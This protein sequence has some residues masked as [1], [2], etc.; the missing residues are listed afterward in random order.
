M[1]E[2]TSVPSRWFGAVAACLLLAASPAALGQGSAGYSEYFV[3]ADEDNM[4][5]IFN[6]LDAGGG[7]TMRSVVVVTAWAP[8][9]TIYVDHWENGYDFDPNNPG[10]PAAC[11]VTTGVLASSATC[12]VPLA[13]AG[14][15]RVFE[16][17]NIP[18]PRNP[19]NAY[20]DG[21]DRI[22]VAGGAVTVTRATGL[23]GRWAGDQASAWEVYPVKPQLTTYELPFGENLY[24]ADSTNFLGFQRVFAIIQATRD[25]TTFQVDLDGNG[26]WDVLNQNRDGDRTDPGDTNTVTL[27]AG[28]NFLLDRV[29]ACPTG[30]CSQTTGSLNSRT[31]VQG[32]ETLQVKFVTGRVSSGYTAR[33]LSA[34]P[35]GYWT[36]DYYAPFDQSTTAGRQ[37]DY[38][39]YNPQST[40]LT[41]S[42]Q[43][44]TGSGS[45][46]LTPGQ[47][48]SYRQAVGAVPV[49]SGLYFS[50]PAEF[51]GVGFGDSGAN[52]YEWGYSLLP[53][54]LLYREHFMGW[55][56]G[57]LGGGGAGNYDD[58]GVFLTPAQDNTTIF[59]DYSG[60]GT[61]DA[62]YTLSRL[63]TQYI[64]DPN[65]GN[66]T[67][68]RIWGTGL[69]TMAYGENPNLATITTPS[70]DLGYVAI[71]GT[72]YIDIVL[73][74]D[75]SANPSVVGTAAGSTTTFTLTA[76]TRRYALTTVTIVDDLPPGWSFQN[77]SATITL[78]DLSTISGAAA[79]PT[80]TGGGLTLTWPASLF[81]GGMAPN[82]EIVI[83]YTA[84]APA[85]TAGTLSQNRVTATGTRVVGGI[86]QTFSA[87]NFAYVVSG[88]LTIAKTSDADPDPLF[89]G[90]QFTYT[91]TVSNPAGSPTQTGVTLFDPIP[92][93]LT[94]VAGSGSITCDRN[95]NVRDQFGAVS[96][97]N[98]DGSETW[99]GVWTETDL[100]GTTAGPTAG[101]VLVTGNALRLRFQAANVADNLN[102]SSYGNNTGNTNWSAD[103]TETGDDGAPG[104]GSITV[105]VGGTNRAIFGPGAAGRDLTRT[106]PVSGG[107]V[108]I[109]F[110]LS[111][112]GIDGTDETLVAEYDLG[113][114][115]GFQ[116]IQSINGNGATTGTNPLTIS[117][118]GAT[119]ITLRFRTTDSGNGTWETGDNAG[120]DAVNITY[121]NAVGAAAQRTV[122]LTGTTSPSLSFTTATSGNLEGTETL[123]V[124]ASSSPAGTF[125]VLATA[126]DDG[127]FTPAGPYDLTSYASATT[128]IRFRVTGDYN[129]T[130]EWRS[131][132]DVNVA[133]VRP[134]QTFASGNPPSFLGTDATGRE[135][136]QIVAGGNV[137]LTFEATVND[138]FPTGQ[139]EVTNTA[140]TT[141]VQLPIQITASWTDPVEN[142]SAGSASAGG[143]LWFDVDGDGGQD[144]GETGFANVVVT[145]K[146]EFGTPVA[147]ATTDGNGRYLFAGVS[148]GT[149]YYVEATSGLPP[150]L[151][152]TFP[153]GQ[154][155]NRTTPF[156][157]VDG[158]T[159]T[160]GDIGY[161]TG[162]TTAAFGDRVWV[163]ADADGVQDA[164]E[165]GLGGAAMRLYRDFNGD[166]LLDPMVDTFVGNP[167]PGPG[168]LSVANGSATVTGTGTSFLTLAAGD[169]ITIAGVTYTIQSVTSATQLTLTTSYTGTTGT[170]RT[171]TAATTPGPGTV[172]VSGTAVTATVPAFSSLLP[173]DPFVVN[174]VRYRVATVVDAQNLTLTSSAGTATNL[175]Y[176]LASPVVSDP[177][178]SYLFTG[179]PATG[180]ETYFVSASTPSGYLST[181]G[182]VSRFQGV[183]AGSTYLTADFGF[184]AT[185]TTYSIRDRVWLD[186][187]AGGDFDS[188]TENGIGG[189]TVDLL[190]GSGNVIGT[191]TTAAD[192][193]F[194]FSGLTGGTVSNP[195]D[196]TVRVTDNAGLLLD[197]VGT[198][199]YATSHE[200][201]E[202]IVTSSVDRT[203]TGA[204]PSYGYRPVRSIGDFVWNDLDGDNVQDAGEPGLA[205]VVVNLYND[206]N[207]NGIV[208]GA[209][210][211]IATVTTDA[212]G[213]YLFSGLANGSYVVSV[214]TPPSGFNHTGTGGDADSDT[215]TAGI[216]NPA[217]ITLGGNALDLDFG[218]RANTQR[219]VSGSVWRDADADG[220]IDGGETGYQGVEVRLYTDVNGDGTVNGADALVS[221]L[222][223]DASG[224]YSFQGLPPG[225]Y[226]VFLTDFYGVLTNLVPTYENTE[227]VTSAVNYREGVDLT[228][229][230]ATGIRF[231]YRPPAPTYASV[232]SLSAYAGRDGVVVEWR[233][234]LESGT[235]GFDLLRL[236]G[237]GKEYAPV[238]KALL[239][240]LL[241]HP[242]GGSYRALDASASRSGSVTYKLVERDVRGEGREHG[243]YTVPVLQGA[244]P[245]P[246][247]TG[248]AR[249]AAEA[250]Q[251]DLAR[252][253]V[254]KKEKASAEAAKAARTGPAI[255]ITTRE[256][257]LYHVT[258]DEIAKR[259]NLDQLTASGM[260]VKGRFALT[261]GGTAVPYL[262]AETGLTFLAPASESVYS[263]DVVTW[264]TEGQGTL[265]GPLPVTAGAATAATFPETLHREVNQWALPAVFSDPEGDLWCWDYV[266]A[267][268]PTIGTK[269]F[270]VRAAGVSGTGLASLKVRLHGGTDTASALDHHVLVSWNG[271][272]V[273]EA[274]WDGT[275]PHEMTI[276][277]PAT[278]V[279]E[280]SNTLTLTGLLDA[281][282]AYSVVYLD[283]FDL[284]Y[285]RKYQA[286]GDEL[287][288]TA[289][290]GATVNVS[291]FRSGSVLVLDVTPGA[292]DNGVVPAKVYG[293]KLGAYSARFA[294]AP[295]PTDRTY[296]ALA[297]SRLRAP[298]R[299]VAV[300]PTGLSN[301]DNRADYLLVAPASL[302]AAAESLADF[303]RTQGFETL[304]VDVEDVYDEFGDGVPSPHALR[305]LLRHARQSW[306][307][308]PRDVTLVGRGTY[309]YQDFRGYGD[310]LVPTL[311][312]ATP[313][314]LAV[315]DVRIGDLDG[316]DG[317][318]EVAVGRLPVLT[319][320]ELD[321]Y[322]AKAQLAAGMSNP[323]RVLMTADNP[324]LAGSFPADSD[325]VAQLVPLGQQVDKVYLT[326]HTPAQGRQAILTSAALGVS[327]FNYIGHGGFDRLASESLFQSSDVPSLANATTPF[328]FV[329][330]TCAV[331]NFGVPGFP[332]LSERLILKTT[333]GAH[334]TWAATGLSENEPGVVLNKALFRNAFVHGVRL[335]GDLVLGAFEAPEAAAVPPFMRYQFNL[336]GEPV[337]TLPAAP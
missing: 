91:V 155:A 224:N 40:N 220:V 59:V 266:F 292:P 66:L 253:A 149:G 181:N 275:S 238:N 218:F 302:K 109:S 132:D 186:L 146:D 114:G 33:G 173:G 319:S 200:R 182:T 121:N 11:Q 165:V 61:T 285:E 21:R 157:L 152:Q 39:L 222:T 314:G 98:D 209:D 65:D 185:T 156:D 264:L 211:V 70:L 179:A 274:R 312:A 160:Q 30:T 239:P 135:G 52:A 280:G 12:S 123:V 9:T 127:A 234:S 71:P 287:W 27:Q 332:S 250:Q 23:E 252:I 139:T 305:E 215:G 150:G 26:T 113:L 158:Q 29:S 309:D 227:G 256:R 231:G 183:T 296:L 295:G 175:A 110:T 137:T 134:G 80:I 171:Y 272:T 95:R 131:V 63:Q 258:V 111:D 97:S 198:S 162:T 223:T 107:S 15:L 176:G 108:T 194:S 322:L 327:V 233:T 116:L 268:S 228:S 53:S 46:V 255:K 96:Y 57:Y 226:T 294:A 60:D 259:L 229:T 64:Y 191:T 126:T 164:G 217:T 320:Q 45:F 44:R 19:A 276:P 88:A 1:T 117:T 81:P 72:D 83:S 10:S 328:L 142:P 178:G 245:D 260:I 20:Y 51:W 32:S 42:W 133:Y 278:S 232:A 257:G 212:N 2:R 291:G 337:G 34:F 85:S 13:T 36:S 325:V 313:Y 154:P 240:G 214:P 102:T 261:R 251:A 317:L 225:T 284:S 265:L 90:D 74:V 270:T 3:P 236:S 118:A 187:D 335:L 167:T 243:P 129:A 333:G 4:A 297:T 210:A 115:G 263:A 307:L 8:N 168:I 323:A 67:G 144:V 54:T 286:S 206:G 216:Q 288:F 73:G 242:Q 301:A 196:Y 78:P 31:V 311:M 43:S 140:A 330:T 336:L 199:T 279:V 77:D 277:I 94:Y 28:Q 244:A 318:P 35:R 101:W 202:Q 5:A 79:N 166:G 237:D 235:A 334:A 55:A 41:V 25:N 303:R 289:P 87:T 103:W 308:S 192:G 18:T 254:L 89:P 7:T 293:L 119:T 75:K 100:Q 195:A 283:S 315:S 112:E 125:T 48:R 249:A 93:G 56:P 128:T 306:S 143:R 145:L 104:T 267:G 136:C 159:Y 174:G 262:A 169:P 38:Y 316:D 207:G 76:E 151:V 130:N 161:R 69:F 17:A 122:N 271:V 205:G 99:A 282:V 147:T 298:D 221:T 141:T 188:G 37:T 241:V 230:D 50:A 203:G 304:V 47:T 68:A 273:G 82:Q 170:G 329:G 197:M 310:N 300:E 189:V 24:A 321:D 58:D 148:P 201:L 177:D 180:V 172:S 86:T 49:G 246:G 331:G 92:A 248:F 326:T 269:S 124:E 138:P 204:T 14:A 6:V 120:V 213:Q 219:S 324:D 290:A 281:G 105:D 16:S 106:A 190:D 22:Y 62:T 208:D 247:P 84:V 193:T 153:T 184:N 299:V 163:D